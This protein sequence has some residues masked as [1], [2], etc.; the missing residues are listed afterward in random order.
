MLKSQKF[1]LIFGVNTSKLWE[2]HY[3]MC[4]A[5]Y[6]NMLVHPPGKYFQ[7]LMSGRWKSDVFFADMVGFKVSFLEIPQC[8]HV[9]D[10]ITA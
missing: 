1:L 10:L 3:I 6:M 9:R 4:K 8:L 2:N 7:R 5:E